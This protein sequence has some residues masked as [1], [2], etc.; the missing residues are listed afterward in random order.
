MRRTPRTRPLV[1]VPLIVV[2]CLPALSGA[3]RA[4]E[5]RAGLLDLQWRQ[6]RGATFLSAKVSAPV[7]YRTAVSHGTITIDLW[8]VV[9]DVDRSLPIPQGVVA[10]VVVRRMTPEVIRLDIALRRASRFKVYQGDGVLTVSV[11]PEHLSTVPLPQSVAYQ[12]L[13]APT[14][15]G[16]ARVH[17][18]TID[19]QGQALTVRPALGG[20][21]V[22]ATETTSAAATRLEALAAINGNFY[23]SAGLPI[24]LIVIDGRVLST[25]F[26]RRAVFSVDPL[27]RPRIGPVEF[28]GRIV[29]DTGAVIPVSAV[30]RPPRAGGVAVYTPEFGPLTRPQALVA[31][32]RNDRVEAF[33]SGRP[34]IPHN[35]Y[36]LAAAASEQHLLSGLVRGQ[37][38][39]FHATLAPS[40]VYHAVQ[41]GPQLVREGR[42]FVPYVWEGFSASFVRLRTARSAIGITRAGKVLFVAVDGHSR[43]SGMTLDELAALMHTLGA[44]DAMNLDGGGSSTLVVGGRVV[45]ALPRG[46]ER[47]VSSMLVALRRTAQSTP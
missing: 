26:P 5:P 20:A 14:G 16:R 41:G 7:R 39:Q 22:A 10:Q 13:Q 42:V 21:V 28:A 23:T 34:V 12:T 45:T 1:L 32:I 8:T 27:G 17:V 24:G 40:D 31:T 35:G 29:T 38:V 44:V 11:F 33:G 3:A 2:L 25:P 37:G 36:A 30:N 19:P 46:G 47:T 9:G 43:H 4:T 18:V 6:D 15:R